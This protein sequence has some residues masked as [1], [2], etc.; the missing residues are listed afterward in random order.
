MTRRR[1]L[2]KILMLVLIVAM[3][4]S[5]GMGTASAAATIINPSIGNAAAISDIDLI[6]ANAYLDGTFGLDLITVIK[7]LFPETVIDITYTVELYQEGLVFDSKL[8]T[9]TFHHRIYNGYDNLVYLQRDEVGPDYYPI[10]SGTEAETLLRTL[11]NVKL[12]K[13]SSSDDYYIKVQASTPGLIGSS[14]TPWAQ[15]PSKTITVTSPPS[16]TW[17]QEITPGQTISVDVNQVL[18]LYGPI[19]FN[20]GGNSPD[21]YVTVTTDSTNLQLL[22]PSGYS[23]STTTIYNGAT[24]KVWNSA[25]VQT[26]FNGYLA[27]ANKVVPTNSFV[28]FSHLYIK[29]TAAGTYRV[30]WRGALDTSDNGLNFVRSPS[31]GTI[32]DPL[33]YEAKYVTINAI[34]VDSTN[35]TISISSPYD[36]QPFT[37][38][39]VTVSGSASDAG[40]LSKVEVKVGSGSWQLASLSG[41]LWTKSVTLAP[42]SNTIYVKATDTSNNIKEASVVVTY[43]PPPGNT[44]P[45]TPSSPSGPSSG[46][47]G[48]SYTF[49]TSTTDPNGVKI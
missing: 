4:L 47:T 22:N 36:G 16:I 38:S 11:D 35:P 37:T 15:S 13:I 6:T 19:I 12:T 23:S 43:T 18:D 14:T 5:I 31:S 44:A 17:S 1:I 20:D 26:N 29:P 40:G 34:E 33:G 32:T 48:T 46:Y 45:N 27:D 41:T 21:G 9:Y 24:Q 25:G 49:S 7:S 2:C 10:S 42:G 8:G 39:A 28:G 3:C 30:Y